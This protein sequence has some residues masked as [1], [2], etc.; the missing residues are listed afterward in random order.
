[1]FVQTQ[2]LQAPMSGSA[3][4]STMSDSES[5]IRHWCISHEFVC[6]ACSKTISMPRFYV[7]YEEYGMMIGKWIVWRKKSQKPTCPLGCKKRH[8]VLTNASAIEVSNVLIL[9]GDQVKVNVR[10]I[11]GR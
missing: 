9:F 11:W 1:M 8:M 3:R 2:A 5:E 7:P 6:S 4:S 10:F